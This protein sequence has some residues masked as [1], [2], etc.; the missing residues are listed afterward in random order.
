LPSRYA[1]LLVERDN[2]S[3]CQAYMEIAGAIRGDDNDVPCGDV[4]TWLRAACTCRG[5]AGAQAMVPIVLQTLPPVH[6]PAAV[7]DYVSSKIA[8]DFPAAFRGRDG[9][10]PD[11]A[12]VVRALSARGT[13]TG[14]P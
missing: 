1:A 7:H 2:V 6:L 12:A 4:L 9:L 10:A 14:E 5:G 13:T 3:P 11:V 8:S